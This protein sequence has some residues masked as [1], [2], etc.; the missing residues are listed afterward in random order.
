[1][2]YVLEFRAGGTGRGNRLLQCDANC[3]ND[4]RVAKPQA[5][6]SEGCL[7]YSSFGHGKKGKELLTFRR[8]H[9]CRDL[10]QDPLT[11]TANP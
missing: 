7:K 9:V 11:S 1:M 6:A 2:G 3:S 10:Q 8:P 4:S 5:A